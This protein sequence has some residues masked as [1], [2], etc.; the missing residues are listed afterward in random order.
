M[1]NFAEYQQRK[2]QKALEEAAA[3]KAK[4]LTEPNSSSNKTSSA[5]NVPTPS[6]R[7]KNEEHSNRSAQL[8]Q[9]EQKSS[10][11]KNSRTDPLPSPYQ[12]SNP[13]VHPTPPVSQGTRLE[14]SKSQVVSLR[15]KEKEETNGRPLKKKEREEADIKP[16]WN[17]LQVFINA[18]K[19]TKRLPPILTADLPK[20]YQEQHTSMK[21]DKPSTPSPRKFTPIPKML[22]PTLPP[23]YQ[24]DEEQPIPSLK[25]F[26]KLKDN[27]GY[28]SI[29]RRNDT[30]WKPQENF[31]RKFGDDEGQKHVLKLINTDQGKKLL[32]RIRL[33]QSKKRQQQ[34]SNN[35]TATTTAAT[36]K[37]KVIGLGITNGTGS[38]GSATTRVVRRIPSDDED[39]DSPRKKKKVPT[40]S[41]RRSSS[42]QPHNNSSSFN[43]SPVRS[44]SRT[45]SVPTDNTSQNL[46]KIP[47]ITAHTIDSLSKSS[48]KLM[49]TAKSAKKKGDTLKSSAADTLPEA[50]VHYIDCISIYI[51]AF[52]HEDQMKKL[53]AKA[54]E[55]KRWLSLVSFLD[56]VL[57][58][59]ESSSSDLKP[60]K[61]LLNQIKMTISTHLTKIYSIQIDSKLTQREDLEQQ[62]E[63]AQDE[64]L[65]LDTE[66]MHDVRNQS[67]YF[68]LSQTT[69]ELGE[70]N[71]SVWDI[72]DHY[73]KI[74]ETFKS[75]SQKR[76]LDDHVIDQTLEDELLYL[77]IDS[78]VTLG[79][80]AKYS[81]MVLKNWCHSK[82][83]KFKSELETMNSR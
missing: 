21:L 8:N 17:E 53:E 51:I 29:S 14:D 13:A 83:N 69:M 74:Y 62:G 36:T 81:M 43:K 73:H 1:V 33:N 18:Y 52:N 61:G 24:S 45:N 2:K 35:T 28:Q 30:Y 46:P 66:M 79:E 6:K 38:S 31:T 80:I 82:S 72:M 40:T 59:I 77:P 48:E 75:Q 4:A 67:K 37:Q 57:K 27:S 68:K 19:T 50:I 20:V 25:P 47:D 15:N 65:K 78:I 55:P 5:L 54:Y 70:R 9:N 7:T 56:Y 34:Q 3:A 12:R 10:V 49:Q 58:Q 22:S 39:E 41:Q 11:K 60:L 64:I 26:P 63:I 23:R 32:F 44:H 42:V 76:N 16:T 71:L